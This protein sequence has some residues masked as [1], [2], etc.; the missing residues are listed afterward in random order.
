MA[1]NNLDMLGMMADEFALPD[2]VGQAGIDP[3]QALQL[4]Q[5]PQGIDRLTALS[6]QLVESQKKQSE[7]LAYASQVAAQ[8]PESRLLKENQTLGQFFKTPDDA[9]R[10]FMVNAGLKL[11]MGDTTKNLSSRLAEALGQGVGAMQSERG[12]ALKQEQAKAAAQLR[13]AQLEGQQTLQTFGLEKDIVQEQR[14]K[15]AARNKIK[16]KSEILTLA[17]ERN[18]LL[19]AGD[20][21]SLET[22]ALIDEKIALVNQDPLLKEDYKIFAKDFVDLREKAR[23]TQKMFDDA[24]RAELALK[25]ADIGFGSNVVTLT[26]KFANLI[27]VSSFRKGISATE[28]L[29]QVLGQNVLDIMASGD[30]GAG[31]GLSD[32]DVEFAREVAAGT[33]TL[34]EANIRYA[35]DIKRRAANYAR[36]KYNE[37]LGIANEAFPSTSIARNKPYDIVDFDYISEE[38]R[39]LAGMPEGSY[40]QSQQIP[41]RTAGVVTPYQ[42]QSND[43]FLKTLQGF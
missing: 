40:K 9:Q 18:A 13:S 35:I 10:A 24:D 38:S 23:K 2:Y 19:K 22:A 16:P 36:E 6:R 43:E 8:R 7:A 32:K 37:A 26:K 25:D 3:M 20:P 15:D 11:A 12:A 14:L 4:T 41:G 5:E 34:T 21:Q 42:G 30:L 33:K 17:D 27:G 1:I 28:A 31:T 39:V 29:S